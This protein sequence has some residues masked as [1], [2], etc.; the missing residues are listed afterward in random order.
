MWSLTIFGVHF[1]HF[2]S[3]QIFCDY[4]SFE[5]IKFFQKNHSDYWS[6]SFQ[7][8]HFLN[9]LTTKTCDYKAIWST[10]HNWSNSRKTC[11]IHP[12]FIPT[13]QQRYCLHQKQRCQSKHLKSY[14]IFNGHMCF[15]YSLMCLNLQVHV[16]V[17]LCPN[18]ASMQWVNDTLKLCVGMKKIS[19][20]HA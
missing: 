2:S 16:L 1:D 3:P 5:F 9:G 14:I 11:K 7:S 19:F 10:E 17:M 20:K 12:H 15:I 6:H 4:L 18:H 8:N 13:N